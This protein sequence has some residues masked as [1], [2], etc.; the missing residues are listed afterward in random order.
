MTEDKF[1]NLLQILLWNDVSVMILQSEG[2]LAANDK[3]CQGK[4]R[5]EEGIWTYWYHTVSSFW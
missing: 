5:S 3:K 2:V 4:G 1:L